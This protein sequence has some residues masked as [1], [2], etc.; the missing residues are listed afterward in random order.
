MDSQIL[1]GAALNPKALEDTFTPKSGPSVPI[2]D[3]FASCNHVLR[4]GYE[5]IIQYSWFS[6]AKLNM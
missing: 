4:A 1:L 2:G 3:V 5:P 6:T